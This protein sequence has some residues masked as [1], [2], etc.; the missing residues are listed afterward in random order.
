VQARGFSSLWL[1]AYGRVVDESSRRTDRSDPELIEFGGYSGRRPWRRI[2]LPA[3]WAGQIRPATVEL[4]VAALA[5]GLLIGFGAGRLTSK[6]PPVSAHRLHG[7]RGSLVNP[8]FA[9]APIA[10]TGGRCA[11][12]TGHK[13]EL[14]IEIQDQSTKPVSIDQVKPVFA[15]GGFRTLAS[16]VG[17][18]GAL[19]GSLPGTNLAP[20][21]P[22]LPGATEWVTTTA[23]VLVP[24]P[25]ALPVGF[26]ISY[27]QAGRSAAIVINSFPDLGQI[28][29]SG[30][31]HP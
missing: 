21:G 11:V 15:L 14:G 13:L 1:A 7:T 25:T 10:D 8:V 18:C 26:K 23:A 29:Y 4:A 30:C 2:K 28:P 24:C 27:R 16:G 31:H 9:V 22:L 20:P 19:P 12:Q 6:H 17:S 5:V 3:G